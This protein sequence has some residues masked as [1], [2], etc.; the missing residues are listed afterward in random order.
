MRALRAHVT[1]TELKF[2]LLQIQKSV[3]R[4]VTGT[5]HN[6][7]AVLGTKIYSNLLRI[8]ISVKGLACHLNRW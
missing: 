4:N 1:V 2:H 5:F 3:F 6:F 7:S 8:Y